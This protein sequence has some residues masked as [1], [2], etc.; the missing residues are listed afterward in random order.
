MAAVG[1]LAPWPP[2]SRRACGRCRAELVLALDERFG[3]AGRRL[4][5]RVPGVAARRRPGRRSP[6]SGASTRWPGT[7]GPAGL[8]TYEVFDEVS[9]APGRGRRPA[10]APRP[11]VGGARGVRRLRRRGGA[12]HPGR[13]LHRVARPPARRRRPGRPRAHRRRVGAV[14]RP[15]S[16]VA[17]LLDQLA[18]R[19]RPGPAVPSPDRLRFSGAGDRPGDAAAGR[20]GVVARLV[21]GGGR[22]RGRPGR[23]PASSSPSSCELDHQIAR[24]AA[25]T[26]GAPPHHRPDRAPGRRSRTRRS[27]YRPAAWARMPP[28]PAEPATATSTC[29]RPRPASDL[30]RPDDGLVTGGRRQLSS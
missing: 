23:R 14:G 13:G 7:A 1:Q 15:G 17:A 16:I 27:S 22:T 29:R 19:F 6:S 12:G 5:Q 9:A 26:G 25:P 30:L 3:R 11:A 18:H 2:W 28:P 24:R 21:A 10:G 8:G 20:C 4:R